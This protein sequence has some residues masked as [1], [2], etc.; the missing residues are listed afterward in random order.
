M[1]NA[2]PDSWILLK[3]TEYAKKYKSPLSP[4]NEERIVE[5]D[6]EPYVE[7]I[8]VK[9]YNSERDVIKCRILFENG[10]KS[11]LLFSVSQIKRLIYREKPAL[12]HKS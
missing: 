12:K 1:K 6:T 5:L 3:P 7:E 4:I 11:E 9:S 8:E 10:D 2:S